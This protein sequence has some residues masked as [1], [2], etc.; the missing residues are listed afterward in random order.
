MKPVAVCGAPL[1]VSQAALQVVSQKVIEQLIHI[2]EEQSEAFLIFLLHQTLQ[3]PL[4]RHADSANS[5]MMFQE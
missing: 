5:G 3:I 1:R 4:R 2:F